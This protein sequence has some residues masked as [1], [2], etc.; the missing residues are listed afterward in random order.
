MGLMSTVNSLFK[1]VD[2]R[3]PTRGTS[4]FRLVQDYQLSIINYQLIEHAYFL[5]RYSRD[6]Q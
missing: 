2:L 1:S 5:D 6:A 3:L 4:A